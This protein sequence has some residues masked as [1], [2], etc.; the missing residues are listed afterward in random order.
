MARQRRIGARFAGLTVLA[1]ALMAITAGL[2]WRSRATP[3][4]LPPPAATPEPRVAPRK[5]IAVLGFRNVSGRPDA[6]WLS[7][8]FA[9]C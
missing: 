1:A 4:A 3:I 2:V 8:A 5:S 9:R 6:A 7:T